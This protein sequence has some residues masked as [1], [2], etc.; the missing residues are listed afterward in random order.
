MEAFMSTNVW[1]GALLIFAVRVINIALSTMRVFMVVRGRK[2]LAW[3]LGFLESALYVLVFSYV[4][5]DITNFIN[6]IA[7]AGGFATGNVVGMWVED[8]MAV[9]HINVRVISPSRGA[10]ISERLRDEGFA[11]TEV[12]GR[13]K[14]GMVTL[15]NV[16]VMRRDLKRVQDIVSEV[17][18]NAFISAEELRPLQRGFWGR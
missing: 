7:Y 4:L 5:Q 1:L 14:D 8:R 13:G 18:K 15:L 11:V 6:L 9:G 17:D 10:A 2:G 12:S 16:S 3:I